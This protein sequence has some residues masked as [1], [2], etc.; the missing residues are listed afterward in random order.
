MLITT[1][2]MFFFKVWLCKLNSPHF[3]TVNRP[4]YGRG[5]DFKQVIVESTSNNCYSPTSGKCFKKCTNN[6]TGKDYTEDF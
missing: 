4:H 6:L 3:D 5:I 1:L 2:N